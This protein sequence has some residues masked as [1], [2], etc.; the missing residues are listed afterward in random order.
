MLNQIA[1]NLIVIRVE[2]LTRSRKFYEI[3]GISFLY[4]QHGNGEK[5]LSAMLGGIVFEIY[6]SSNNIDTSGVRLGFRV[7]SVDNTIEEL[8]A[9]E[10]VIVS[11]PKDSQWGRRA[12]I[13]DPDGH[14]I[15]L[16]D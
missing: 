11:P 12:V 6:P 4:E 3:L 1:L 9:I 2:D 7:S 16:V 13:I 8:Q 5:H 15:E 14:K 10:T